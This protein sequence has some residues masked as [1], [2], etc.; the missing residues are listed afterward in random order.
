MRR[1]LV[2]LGW[3]AWVGAALGVGGMWLR[4][5]W[6]LD[7]LI[8]ASA[9][10][11]CVVLRSDSGQLEGE[12][13]V[14]WPTD[15]KM[16][17]LRGRPRHDP[18]PTVYRWTPPRWLFPGIR[19][20]EGPVNVPVKE[21]G[22]TPVFNSPAFGVG[23]MSRGLASAW[24]TLPYPTLLALLLV[25]PVVKLARAAMDRRRRQ[26]RKSH[27]LCP[28]CAYDLRA[29]QERCPECGTPIDQAGQQG[30]P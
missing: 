1:R 3:S 24:A 2:I 16:R 17:W 20:R 5:H 11:G 10:R 19:W 7:E 22:K 6:T 30:N 23:Q 25:A 13:I 8:W 27:G 12:W 28:E 14:P 26:W 4:S 15:Q 18:G 9:G 29:S 21:D